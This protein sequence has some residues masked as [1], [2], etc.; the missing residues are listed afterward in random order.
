MTTDPFK[1]AK[2]K[3]PELSRLTTRFM[4]QDWV[5]V[6]DSGSLL[7]IEVIGQMFREYVDQ[8]QADPEISAKVQAEIQ[9]VL[10]STRTVQECER[11]LSIEN[12]MHD[13]FGVNIRIVLQNLKTLLA[14]NG[15][16]VY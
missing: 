13:F 3:Y 8:W 12:E 10:E 14:T 9:E 6:D 16:V 4:E 7:A 15:H 5:E 2:D 1:E 11:A